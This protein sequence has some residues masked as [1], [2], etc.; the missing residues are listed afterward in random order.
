[1]EETKKEENNH[2]QALTENQKKRFLRIYFHGCQYLASNATI[3][4][5]GAE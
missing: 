3:R 1:M 5:V 2:V 4:S